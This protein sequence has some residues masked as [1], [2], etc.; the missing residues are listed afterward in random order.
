MP[1]ST[2]RSAEGLE[3]IS[4]RDALTL[5]SSLRA[6]F[7]DGITP[8]SPVTVAG[9]NINEADDDSGMRWD[10]SAN[11]VTF[12]YGARGGP[13][14]VWLENRFSIAFRLDLA[15]RFGLGGV[16]VE[17]AAQDETLP[18]V[19]NTVATF[20]ED[21]S[22][23]RELPYGPYLK[24]SWLSS[25]GAWRCPTAVPTCEWPPIRGSTRW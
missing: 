19:W 13:H 22:V 17:P 10:E 18:D 6:R 23:R 3:A 5:A 9:T 2:E 4:L 11:A 1:A 21:G 14:S 24:P 12:N 7:D 20:V 8:G 16:V 25:A 15:R